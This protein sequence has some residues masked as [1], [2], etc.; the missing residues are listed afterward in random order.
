MEIIEVI[1]RWQA[2]ESRRAIARGAG[3]SRTTVD[4]YLAEAQRQGLAVGGPPPSEIQQ[5]RLVRFGRGATTRG[6]P[7]RAPLVP[8]Q[9]RIAHWLTEERLQLTRVHELL[10]QDGM[11]VS[12]TT[13]RRFVVQEGLGRPRRTT[14][15]VAEGAPGEVAEM[16]F[17][18]LGVLVDPTTRKRV[19][20]WAL[21]V[22]LTYSRHQF[23]WPLIQQTLV[24]VIAGLEAAWRL[25]GGVPQ[26]LV[27]DNFPSA[28]ADSDPL[29][30]RPTRGFLEY[31][32]ARGFLNDPARRAHPQDKPHVE[33]GV[34]YARER[35]WKGGSFI[36][37]ADGRRQA[38]DWCL[39][40]AGQRIHGTTR[41]VPLVVFEDEERAML[42]PLAATPYGD[43]PYDVPVWRE[44]TV[45]PDH[46]IQLLQALYSVP[47]STCPPG[48]KLEGRVDRD[49]VRL[50]RAG[51]L[52]KVHPRKP[53]GGRATDP[54]DYPAEKTAY[55]MRAPDRLVRQATT[56]GEHVG[57]FATQ[58]FSGPLPWS[59][60]RQGYRLLRLGERY[61]PARLDAACARALGFDLIDVRRVERILVHALEH[62]GLPAVPIDR[63]MRALPA[64]RF[65][66]P[67]AAFDHRHDVWERE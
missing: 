4:K 6:A 23:L 67:G 25:F 55:A 3:V 17:E 64:G 52:V 36:D 26:R 41:R 34:P 38:I 44:L 42:T 8:H 37:L 58:L 15:R 43:A 50:Y 20:V 16:D 31:S 33:R 56:L 9:A 48:T 63:R 45:H 46:H 24:E 32:Q 57:A 60:L 14:V 10:A 28:I 40:V 22:V 47:S 7:A 5:V 27:L 59:V 49:L 2:G 19:T 18:R 1:R 61:T 30:P 13:L 35:F 54:D 66:R 53:K 21:L 62:E 29:V 51:E 65:A 11:A 12:Y 39:H